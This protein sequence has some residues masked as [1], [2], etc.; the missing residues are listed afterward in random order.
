MKF[1]TEGGVASREGHGRGTEPWEVHVKVWEGHR[2]MGGAC[3]G[4]GG[5]QNHG[6]CM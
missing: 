5:A 6:R 4:M 3:E 1:H 2:T